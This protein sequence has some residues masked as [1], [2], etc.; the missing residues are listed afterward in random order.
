MTEEELKAKA[1]DLEKKEGDISKK[2]EELNAKEEA[3]AKREADAAGLAQTIKK[4]FETRLEAQKKEFEERLKARE[5]I[6]RQLASGEKPQD[7][8]NAFD[9][10]NERRRAQKAA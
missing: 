5:D 4:E 3:L 8:P 7:E 1:A 2:E 10:I 9:K 6:I